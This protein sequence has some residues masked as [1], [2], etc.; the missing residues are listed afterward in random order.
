[1]KPRSSVLRPAASRPRLSVT[2]RRPTATSTMSNSRVSSL[3]AVPSPLSVARTPSC[4][5]FSI[6][7]TLVFSMI[8]MPCFLRIRPSV[9][10][11][12][13][14]VPVR[15][16]GI[17]STTKTSRAQARVDGRE[18]EAD[19]AA[20]DHQQRLGM[21]ARPTASS[22]LMI[23]SPSRGHALTSTGAEP[24]AIT[25][26]CRRDRSRCRRR[27]V[28]TAISLAMRTMPRRAETRRRWL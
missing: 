5:A 19:D 10:P 7:P 1:M 21:R 13:R 18:L 2:G 6:A 15:I 3:P 9:L 28:L 8:S 17:I 12:S 14:S 24:V 11:I 26:Y 4:R 20:A 22:E 27:R 23:V 25:T 16:C